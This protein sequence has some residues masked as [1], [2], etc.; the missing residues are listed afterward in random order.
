MEEMASA[1]KF[2]EICFKYSSDADDLE[3]KISQLE[4]E[5]EDLKK[6]LVPKEAAPEPS[7]LVLGTPAVPVEESPMRESEKVAEESEAILQ[8]VNVLRQRAETITQLIDGSPKMSPNPEEK[9]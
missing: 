5:N 8:L 4:L 6:Q 1:E 3:M 2:K 7:P 9:E